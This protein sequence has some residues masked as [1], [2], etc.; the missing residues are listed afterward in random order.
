MRDRCHRR[1]R[2]WSTI[3]RPAVA[4]PPST[5]ASTP[6]PGRWSRRDDPADRA[7]D[8]VVELAGLDAL[9]HGVRSSDEGV[10]RRRA[11]RRRRTGRRSRRSRAEANTHTLPDASRPTVT[12]AVSV[13]ATREVDGRGLGPTGGARV[14]GEVA[15]GAGSGRDQV[16]LDRGACRAG[17][18]E[19]RSSSRGTPAA[20]GALVQPMPLR[21]SASRV[22][23]RYSRGEPDV[24]GEPPSGPCRTSR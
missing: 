24:G 3:G 19:S 7:V 23:A 21:L 20:N 15:G 14:D 11:S 8:G 18:D 6:E 9:V 22:V 2:S 17:T 13:A 4:A 1:R 10:E 12:I 16:Q 5:D